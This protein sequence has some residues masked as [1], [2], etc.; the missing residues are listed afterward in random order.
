MAITKKDADG[1]ISARTAAFL[2]LRQIDLE[3]AYSNIAFKQVLNQVLRL[4]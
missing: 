3:D 1:N 4:F 2:A